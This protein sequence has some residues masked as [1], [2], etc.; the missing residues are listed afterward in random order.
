MLYTRDQLNLL[1]TGAIQAFL[2]TESIDQVYLTA[3]EVGGVMTDNIYPT[4]FIYEDMMTESN[5]IRTA[6]L[7]NVNKLLFLGLPC[8]Y[9][10]QAT[11]PI[12]ENELLQRAL[13]ST[14]K[15][16][17]II[18]ITGIEPCESYSR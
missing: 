9:P 2:A 17:A 5:I 11:Q 1:D 6:H 14:S 12:A 8:I 15:P 4:D 3:T 10:R 7:Y 16:Y 18:K 13:G